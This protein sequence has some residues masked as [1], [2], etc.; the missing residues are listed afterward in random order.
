MQKFVDLII[1][2][3]L[4]YVALWLNA[5]KAERLEVKVKQME[6]AERAKEIER[7]LAK[8]LDEDLN[9]IGTPAAWNAGAKKTLL[10]FVA[11]ISLSGC[12]KYIEGVW[13]IIPAL[14]RPEL[15]AYPP[16]W[17][18]REKIIAGYAGKLEVLIE[19]YNKAA[20]DHNRKAGSSP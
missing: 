20:E 6:S 14:P 17:S 1:K 19:G 15:P 12:V 3:V 5:K 8:K 7:A 11:V 2:A 13:P 9:G 16:D 10:I 18:E 4:N